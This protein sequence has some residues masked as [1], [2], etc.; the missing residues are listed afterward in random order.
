MPD[1]DTI[2]SLCKRRGFVFPS[3]EI[4]GGLGGFWDYGPLGVE[5]K[6]NIKAAWWKAMVQERDD[7]VGLDCSIIMNPSVWKAS[8]HVTEFTDPDG[9]LQELQA[10]A[11][12]PTTSIMRTAPASAR[13]AAAS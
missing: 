9:G 6:N 10:S 7:V 2:V 1:M 3:S 5:L 13:S 11:S 8:G 12:A 4:Y